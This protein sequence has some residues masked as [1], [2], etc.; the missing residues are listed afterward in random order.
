MTNIGTA[1]VS[2]YFRWLDILDFVEWLLLSKFGIVLVAV[3]PGN[4]SHYLNDC[5][6]RIEMTATLAKQSV[7]SV[8]HLQFMLETFTLFLFLKSLFS[9][10]HVPLLHW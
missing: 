6:Q 7:K 2:K 3:D 1:E 10:S 8:S 9:Y 4:A 5:R